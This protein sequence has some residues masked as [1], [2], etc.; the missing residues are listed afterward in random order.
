[1]KNNPYVGPRPYERG[2]RRNFYGRNREARDLLALILAQRVVLL[3]AQ[4]GAGKTS[5][6]NAQIIPTLEEKEGFKVLPVA[7]VGSAP[8]PSIAPSAIDNVFVFCALMAL[9]GEQT[10]AETL[11]GHTLRSYI[12]EHF[13]EQESPNA[14]TREE[15][16]PLLLIFDQFEEIFT[17][18]RDRWQDAR[19]F[20]QQITEALDAMPS[21]SV[22]FAMRED[23]VAEVDPYAALLPNRLRAR[24]RMER[25]GPEGG[26]EAIARPAKDVGAPF[27]P[28]V[29]ERLVD[30]L[31]RIKAASY[32]GAASPAGT[33]SGEGENVLGPYIEPVQLQVVCQRLWDS[34]PDQ[35]DRLIQWAEV[36]RYGNIDQA[37]TDFYE[38]AIAKAKDLP[39]LSITERQLRRWFSEQLITPIKTRG[40]ALRNPTET[41]GLP[42]AAVDFLEAQHLIRADVRAGARWYELVHDRLVDPIRYSNRDWEAA[43]QT[44]LR[45]AAKHWQDSKSPALLYRD[46]AL[47]EAFA[48]VATNPDD[49]EP[50]EHEFLQASQHADRIRARTRRL[51]VAGVVMTVLVA[52]AMVYLAIRA[53]IARGE[54]ERAL[55]VALSRQLAAQSLIYSDQQLDLSLLL[56]LEANRILGDDVQIKS[57]LLTTLEAEPQ[58]VAFMHGHTREVDSV[59]LSPDGKLAASGDE[60]G[61]IVLWDTTTHR[62][63]GPPLEGHTAPVNSVA[64]SPDGL[65]LVSGDAGGAIIFWDVAARQP[66]TTLSDADDMI[67]SLAWSPDGQLVAA[68]GAENVTLWDVETRQ[69]VG[70]LDVGETR[71]G[72]S[73]AFSPDD[74]TLASGRCS[75]LEA[76]GTCTEGEVRLWDVETL[77]LID[78]PLIEHTNEVLS[79]AFSPDGELLASGSW[80]ATVIV[81]DMDT[82]EPIGPPLAGHTDYVSAVAFSPD[83]QM[84]ASGSWDNT[85]VVWSMEDQQTEYSLSGHAGAVYSLALGADGRTMIS[86]GADHKV[87]LWN[88]AANQ[89]VG[90]TLA[91]HVTWVNSIA[92]SPDG[93]LIASGSCSQW[94]EETEE[95]AQGEIRLWDVDARRLVGDPLAAH[96]DFVSSVAFSPDGRTLASASYDGSIILWDIS[97][98]LNASAATR[99]PTGAPLAEN[100]SMLVSI[101]FSPDGTLLASGAYNGEIL[102][103]NLATRQPANK[104]STDQ[105]DGLFSVAF[106]PDGKLL[107]SGG[108]AELDER[109]TC[110]RGGI[111][112]WDVA[113]RQLIAAPLI[114]HTNWVLGLAFSPDGKLL[115]SS[116]A[117]KSIILWDV[118]ARQPSGAPLTGHTAWV[119]SVAFSP[120][121]KLLASGS[122]DM[123]VILWDAASRRQLGP[124]LAGHADWVNSVAF[125]GVPRTMDDSTPNRLVL[126]SGSNDGGIILW[127]ANLESWK[128]RA[129]QRANRNLNLTEWTGSVN[130]NP[131]S[132]KLTCP[133]LPPGEG[134]SGSAAP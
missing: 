123:N 56:S 44:P 88:L 33:A 109:A 59:A 97:T 116:S 89:S 42:N 67:R 51:T 63:I 62:S 90:E 132:Y 21:L 134:T 41:A 110:H 77:E 36:E 54:A 29:A 75:H 13:I 108:C 124:P 39:G 15:H 45:M 126:A 119:R 100:L 118:A 4:S 113:T 50:Y 120:D 105:S 86:G 115:A 18:H 104:L 74:Q 129:C 24:F 112:L 17:T 14:F 38:S 43:R 66:I 31:R 85:I 68:G 28:G 101:A 22:L 117:D 11:T 102:L 1:M 53:E 5:L 87:I 27:A 57:S 80:D 25:L 48:W 76:N 58:L 52:L 35:Q 16:K 73:V 81:W 92:S 9:A 20:F 94:D 96:A 93:Q 55:Q 91:G 121:G 37:L 34:L 71:K 40:L 61:D 131:S 83:G 10:P 98:A 99:Q 46:K 107:A 7:R 60:T 32:A 47:A 114:Q 133:D 19:G 130:A 12:Q 78:D 30:D 122:D 3:Y 111:Y 69:A 82:G 2:D 65:I 64:F 26:L 72:I 128:A 84:L 95:C 49:V 103:W 125:S 23:H 79:L 106:S 8:P 70:Q 6:L 127:D